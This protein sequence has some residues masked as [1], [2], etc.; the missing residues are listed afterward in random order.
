MFIRDIFRQASMLNV[1]KK[2]TGFPTISP[3]EI[4]PLGNYE[5]IM[6][7][8]SFEARKIPARKKN[9]ARAMIIVRLEPTNKNS[10]LYRIL[11][12]FVFNYL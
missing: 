2:L 7:G 4:R 1:R 5:N 8:E 12:S 6:K 9:T 3:N 11:L 10:A